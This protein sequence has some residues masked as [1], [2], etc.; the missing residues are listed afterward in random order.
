M[1]HHFTLAIVYESIVVYT[2]EVL[3]ANDLNDQ[4]AG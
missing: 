3:V 4:K 2:A 1:R